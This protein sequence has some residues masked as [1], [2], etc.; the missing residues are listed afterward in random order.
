MFNIPFNIPEDNPVLNVTYKEVPEF[1]GRYLAGSD[2]TIH[3]RTKQMKSGL[4]NSGYLKIGFNVRGKLYNRL[5]H[6]I[7]AQ[8]FIPNPENKREVNH[9]DGNKLNNS[10]KNLE[11]VTSAENKQHAIRTGLKIYNVPTLG[12]KLSSSSKFH[13]VS[14]DKNRNKWRASVRHEGKTYHQK[15]FTCELQ[16]ARH[17]DWVLD[18]LG[19]TDRPKNFITN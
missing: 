7:V 13:N 6:R 9:I 17:V 4:I 11:W 3:N 16:A 1:N 2:G 5:V 12:L 14:W 19:L 10:V 15:R 18:T 8:T